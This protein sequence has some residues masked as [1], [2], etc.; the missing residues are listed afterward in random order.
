M[1][2]SCGITGL[3]DQRF[4]FVGVIEQGFGDISATIK[5]LE[6]FKKHVN[7]ENLAL[8]LFANAKGHEGFNSFFLSS[9]SGVRVINSCESDIFYE[10]VKKIQPTLVVMFHGSSR[11]DIKKGF[12]IKHSKHTPLH[13]PAIVFDEYN[14]GTHGCASSAYAAFYALGIHEDSWAKAVQSNFLGI[15]QDTELVRYS[16]NP[17][18]R[19]SLHRLKTYTS[20]L[21]PNLYQAVIGDGDIE[22]FDQ[23]NALYFGYCSEKGFETKIVFIGTAIEFMKET[24]KNLVVVL[25]GFLASTK[26]EESF[27][28]YLGEEK[29][30]S[31]ELVKWEEKKKGSTTVKTF[32]LSSSGAGE[33]TLKVVSGDFSHDHFVQLMLASEREVLCTG[34]QSLSEAL[35]AGKKIYY[36]ALPHKGNLSGSLCNIIQRECAIGGV[37]FHES[38]VTEH[39]GSLK[40]RF[41]LMKMHYDRIAENWNRVI[42]HI[43]QNQN[44]EKKIVEVVADFIGR[45]E[46]LRTS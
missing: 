33:R 32:K 7:P 27:F 9:L 1:A 37:S 40:K 20:N 17:D 3:S 22:K 42:D 30:Q 24:Q 8:T 2:A 28:N 18:N 36:E 29:F 4:L 23:E 25:P 38:R 13:I 39:S 5:I 15:F 35:S 43:H 14:Y 12:E 26:Y 45:Q 31:L 44:C 41:E 11:I 46:T 21:D 19:V 16:Q 10:E 34:D 6:V